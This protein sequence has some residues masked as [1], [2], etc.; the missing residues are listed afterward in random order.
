MNSREEI[1]Q[2]LRSS[3]YFEHIPDESLRKLMMLAE[4]GCFGPGETILRQGQRNDRLFV[5]TGGKVSVKVDGEVIFGLR[6]KGDIFGEIDAVTKNVC[7][8]TVQAVEAVE[9]VTISLAD[10]AEIQNDG[11][12]ELHQIIHVWLTRVLC[13]KLAMA[14]QKAKLY[15]GLNNR[16]LEELQTARSVQ[17][18]VCSSNI[19]TIPGL[20]IFLRSEFADVLGGD[21]YGTFEV[22]SG[23]CGILVGDVSGHGTASALIAMSILNS[24]QLS[25]KSERSSRR[26]VERVNNLALQ[27][28]P[29]SRFITAFYGIFSTDTQE[30]VYTNAGHHPALVLREGSVQRL[31]MSDGIPMG[32]NPAEHAGYSENLFR[33]KK[34]DRLLLF[35]DGVFESLEGKRSGL[36]SQ[37]EH[38]IEEHA[39]LAS[40]GLADAICDRGRMSPQGVRKD[41]FTLM[42]LEVR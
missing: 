2:R 35:T 8:A 30:L 41:D 15:E 37:L 9:V 21:V 23:L 38:F 33:L 3:C 6:R 4:I 1:F 39:G 20:T 36:L 42:I 32:I 27:S 7:S 40:Q 24:F 12:H 19:R 11:S 18:A 25:S 26:V 10:L 16:L 14:S 17:Q 5:I 28:M 22:S 29:S 13:D 34:E 31:P